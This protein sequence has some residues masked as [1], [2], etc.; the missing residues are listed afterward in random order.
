SASAR[1]MIAEMRAGRRHALRPRCEDRA[2]ASDE[3]PLFVAREPRL[4][5][6]AWHAE[7][8]DHALPLKRC[9]AVGAAA[10]IFD[11]ELDI[12]VGHD[13]RAGM[14]YSMLPSAPAMGLSITPRTRQPGCPASQVLIVPHTSARTASSRTMP[15]FPTFSGPASNCGLM[16]ATS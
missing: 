5:P 3:P 14:R 16:S 10:K 1:G 4:H 12:G 8:N 15:P 13:F 11:R 6:I 2:D 7:R 9:N